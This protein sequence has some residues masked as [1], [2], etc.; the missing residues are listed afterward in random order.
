M[1]SEVQIIYGPMAPSPNGSVIYSVTLANGS[2]VTNP[3]GFGMEAPAEVP[4]T[5]KPLPSK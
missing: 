3:S 2:V 5:P 1:S 4:Q